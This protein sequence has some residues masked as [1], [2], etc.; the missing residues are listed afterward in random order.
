[1]KNLLFRQAAVLAC[2]S[3]LGLFGCSSDSDSSGSNNDAGTGDAGGGGGETRALVGVFGSVVDTSGAPVAGATIEVAGTTA[4][5]EADGSF[6]LETSPADGLVVSFRA[7]GHLP[8]FL[9]ADVVA[10]AAS[11]VDATLMPVADPIVVDITA[12]GEATGA[13]GAAVT[14]PPGALVDS[15][16]VPVT[17][18]VEVMLTPYDPTNEA[19]FAA[20]P[21]AL[22]AEQT[23]GSV[24]QLQTYAVLDVTIMQNGEE[25]DVTPGSFIEA[26]IPVPEGLA[27]TPETVGLWS[28]DEE[29][30]IWIEEGTAALDAESGVY[31]AAL[32]HLSPWNCDDPIAATCVEG[33][34]VDSSGAPVPGA[35]VRAVGVDVFGSNET[36]A[37]ADGSFCVFAP[38]SA[39]VRISVIHG[40]GGGTIQEVTTGDTTLA[41]GAQCGGSCTPMEDVV[42][43]PGEVVIE[44][45]GGGGSTINC[46][47]VADPLV[48]T[49]AEGLSSMFECFMASGECV[50]RTDMSG[51]GSTTIEYDNGARIETTANMSG[52]WQAQYFSPSGDLCGTGSTENAES[53]AITLTPASG[54]G[55]FILRQDGSDQ[56]IECPSGETEV[57]SSVEF[58]AFQACF[59][60]DTTGDTCEID[61]GGGGINLCSEDSD[62][63]SGEACCEVGG[64][65]ICTDE[66]TC[67]GFCSVDSDCEVEGEVCCEISG[68]MTC[69][70]QATCDAAAGCS[71][72]SDCA[73][74]EE[75]CSIGGFTT[76]IPAGTC[77]G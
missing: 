18:E 60:T 44:D 25:L 52:M 37:G 77:P 31:I 75:C 19:E 61:M 72:D 21:G 24:V 15:A 12:G 76:C 49:C 47:D 3:A 53:G 50:V 7:D 6:M 17:G 4:T 68:F 26:S 73:E 33:V 20:Y 29:R 8:V 35:R 5:T 43:T 32:P 39:T 59:G 28:F 74:G 46:A 38:P 34:A 16:G 22:T 41:E 66:E 71:D 36:T 9:Q 1:M 51:S 62:C 45:P 69:V 63:E 23:D 2:A 40:E 10:D 13:R 48:G 70:E 54:A 58:D 64:N 67:A 30:G 14:I 56:V 42:I 57:L 11:R 55:P 65:R 27:S